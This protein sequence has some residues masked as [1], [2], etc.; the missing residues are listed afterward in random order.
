MAAD[1]QVK[2][3]TPKTFVVISG[4]GEGLASDLAMTLTAEK[5]SLH[6]KFNGSRLPHFRSMT[7]HLGDNVNKEEILASIEGVLSNKK[8]FMMVLSGYQNNDDWNEALT[9]FMQ[10]NKVSATFLSLDGDTPPSNVAKFFHAVTELPEEDRDILALSRG[11]I[12]EAREQ[13]TVPFEK[14]DMDIPKKAPP[15]LI[16]H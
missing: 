11:A 5:Q 12:K 13:S 1:V 15:P 2:I 4:S 10:S 7:N 14:A 16:L 9:S 3:K 8:N 6:E